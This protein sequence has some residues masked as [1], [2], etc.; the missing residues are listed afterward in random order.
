L[1]SKSNPF[2]AQFLLALCEYLIKQGYDQSMIT[3]L[4]GYSGQLAVFKKVLV[5]IVTFVFVS[6][7]Q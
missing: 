1:K 3:I 2:E 6:C 7:L 5:N 4:T